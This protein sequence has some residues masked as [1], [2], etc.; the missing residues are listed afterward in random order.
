MSKSQRKG[1]AQSAMEYL[2]TYGWAILII[3]VVLAVL[4]QLGVF[5]GGNFAPR[6]QAGACQVQKTAVGSSLVGE[7]QG[8]LP[9]FVGA[10][11]GGSSSKIAMPLSSKLQP[12]SITISAWLNLN[13]YPPTNNEMDFINEEDSLG[14]GWDF[15]TYGTSVYFLFDVPTRYSISFDG[16]TAGWQ[17]GEWVNYVA[18]Y[19]QTSGAITQYYDGIKETIGGGAPTG[20]AL[21]YNSVATLKIGPNVQVPFNGMMANIQIYNNSLNANE[22]L[23]LYQEGIGGAPIRTDTIVGWW[24]LNGNP[25][26]YSGNNNNGAPTSV[27]YSSSWE[28]GY[29]AP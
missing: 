4:F 3:A 9:E 28:S 14:V 25:N 13:S 8:Q 29:A 1:S 12:S 18:T 26:D 22:V 16:P 20:Q 21:V 15:E 23:A 7:C 19:N 2:M 5:S 6:A 17:T 10:W 11:N 24:P 27:G